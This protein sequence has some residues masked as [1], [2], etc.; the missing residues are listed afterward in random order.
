MIEIFPFS[1]HPTPPA[2]LR[3]ARRSPFKALRFL[4]ALDGQAELLAQLSTLG[5][6]SS[7]Q[8]Y[9]VDDSD[10]A[11]MPG[12]LRTPLSPSL[13]NGRLVRGQDSG[14]LMCETS[15]MSRFSSS[16]RSKLSD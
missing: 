14:K 10:G 8:R 13:S 6:A 2:T 5:G 4:L 9:G 16:S 15:A 3:H 1:S 11:G 12:P 7:V